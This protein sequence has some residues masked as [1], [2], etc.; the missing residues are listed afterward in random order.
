[1]KNTYLC[2]PA[3]GG[4]RPLVVRLSIHGPEPPQ[5]ATHKRKRHEKK[6]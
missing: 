5:P 1:M 6:G 3:E 2:L 4:R